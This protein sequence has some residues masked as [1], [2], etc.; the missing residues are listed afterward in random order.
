MDSALHGRE[1][2]VQKAMTG[3]KRWCRI[4]DTSIEPYARVIVTAISVVQPALLL[5]AYLGVNCVLLALIGGLN[6]A[7]W[8]HYAPSLPPNTQPRLFV[9]PSILLQVY[10]SIVYWTGLFIFV[11]APRP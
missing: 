11:M 10:S 9:Y 4:A 6:F 7:V 2:P 8:L 5:L 3:I 1:G